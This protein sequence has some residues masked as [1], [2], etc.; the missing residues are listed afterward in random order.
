MENN[1]RRLA[2]G[3]ISLFLILILYL[4]YLQVFQGNKLVGHQQNKRLL[5]YEAEIARGTIYDRQ[6]RILA[7]TKAVDGKLKRLYPMGE[8]FAHLIGY[9]SIKYGKTGLEQAYDR[10]LLGLNDEQKLDNFVNR[11]QGQ[12]QVGNDLILTVDSQLQGLGRALLGN[13][14]GAVVALDPRNG[15][16]LA[17]VTSPS[18]NPNLIEKTWA[19][20]SGDEEKGILVNRATQ[21]IYPPGSIMKVVTGAGALV[22]DPLLGQATYDCPGYLQI[23]DYRLNDLAVHGQVDFNR[24]MAVSCNTTFGQLGIK[25]GPQDFYDNAL[26]FGFLEDIPFDLPV[27]A[28]SLPEP[29]QLTKA[30]L[31][32]S[33]I[34]QGKVVT[35][36]L[37]MAL[38]AAGIANDG[39][40]MRPKVVAQVRSGDGSILSNPGEKKWKNAVSS[41][42][43]RAVK[44]AMVQ[45]VAEG[46]GRS[47]QLPGLAVAGKT[48]S[49]QNPHGATHAWFIGFAPA[50]QPRV[51][52]AVIVE[53]VGYGGREAAPIARQIMGKALEITR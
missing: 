26:A 43:A 17:L 5:A 22:K 21:G 18:F 19:E 45:V 31:A 8:L 30:G 52:V 41:Q 11:L 53:N 16:V 38:V 39:V 28:G 3:L 25:L 46:T 37:H 12:P 44:D 50:D 10:L 27:K 40:M 9:T 49:A 51:A 6:G 32:Q 35:T 47:A 4:T 15:E 14:R 24:A 2:Y 1:I 20:I 33:A 23:G 13:R 48:G 29:G 34:G 7:E 42:A 36:P